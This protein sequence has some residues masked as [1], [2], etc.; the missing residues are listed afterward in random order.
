[1][2]LRP[3]LLIDGMYIGWFAE[4]GIVTHIE[5]FIFDTVDRFLNVACELWSE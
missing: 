3:T 2:Q 4:D 1:M 5:D